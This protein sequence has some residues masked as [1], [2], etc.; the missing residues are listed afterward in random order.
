MKKPVILIL[1][2]LFSVSAVGSDTLV[3]VA[4]IEF[5]GIR[6]ADKL[7]II[8]KSN[9]RTSKSGILIDLK[10]LRSVM[11]RDVIIKD[12]NISI[13]KN[14]L[15]ISVEEIYPL[16]MIFRTDKDISVPSL[17]DENRNVLHSGGFFKTDMPIIVAE[18]NFLEDA[19]NNEYIKMLFNNLIHIAK[20]RGFFLGELA[21]IKINRNMDLIVSLKNRRTYFI[22]K[23][24]LSGFIRIEK[25]AAYLDAVNIYPE[26][27]NLNDK[28]ALIR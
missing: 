13:D 11:D 7:E 6:N 12:Y 3:E 14:I 28:R 22:T 17:V 8:K 2:I 1:M 26:V 4:G 24:S 16:F 20:T 21:E 9:A 19:R 10:S 5:R 27:V 23:N 15:T 25:S 18:K